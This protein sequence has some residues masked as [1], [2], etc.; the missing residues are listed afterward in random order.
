MTPTISV[1]IPLHG[2]HRWKGNVVAN[3]RALPAMV[4][5]IL[6]SDQTGLDDAAAQLR[7][8]L[9]DDP[10][11]TVLSAETGM[12]FVEHY[13][14]LM[15]TAKGDLFM[16]MPHDDLF[17]AD[18]VPTLAALL[19]EYPKAWLAFG[20]L[21]CVEVDGVTPLWHWPHQAR[22]GL[23]SRWVALRMM[24]FQKSGIPFRGLFRRQAVLAAGLRFDPEHT[25]VA[26][27]KEW[28][29]RVALCAPLAYDE[30]AVVWKR[31]YMGSTST[32]PAWKNQT[33]GHEVHAAIRLLRQHGPKGVLGVSMILY[34]L[35]FYCLYTI[36]RKY[37]NIIKLFK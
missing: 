8:H 13:H 22:R 28:V 11:V 7:E 5:E 10:R 17:A 21:R 29:F 16:W 18:W 34:A 6:I 1:A 35:T 20:Q 12:G 15:E 19:E 2:S 33:R 31:V 36:K 9:A 24:V 23:L 37:I 26:V 14:Y 4:T 32:T 27:D 25:V 30:R 3:V